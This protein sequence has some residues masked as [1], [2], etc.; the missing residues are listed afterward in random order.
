M[1]KKC[2]LAPWGLVFAFV[3]VAALAWSVA[4]EERAGVAPAAPA[5]AAGTMCVHVGTY[6]GSESR[7]IYLLELD[8]SS[9]RWVSG[10][11]LA[12]PSENPSFLALHPSGRFLYA[13]NRG[14]DSIAV[15][16]IDGVALG[17][18]PV[19]H[20]PAGGRAPRHFAIDPSGRWLIAANQDSNSLVVFRLDSATGLP[21]A[22]GSSVSVS[23]PVCVLFAPPI[24]KLLEAPAPWLPTNRA[25]PYPRRSFCPRW[26]APDCSF[27]GT[28]CNPAR[29]LGPALISGQWDS[30]WI[31]WMGPLAG[32]FAA[33][34]VFCR[35][36][37]RIE[38]AKLYR[39]DSA[40]DRLARRAGRGVVAMIVMVLCTASR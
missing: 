26:R 25:S 27:S 13:S 7:G 32:T 10:P 21:V 5:G 9:G 15:F 3:F 8:P 14:D 20:V 11:V 16:A 4:G 12:A 6:T 29:T 37:R 18:T 35:L 23:K 22:V 19:G 17:L 40:H 1:P 34:L 38:V 33:S 2:C 39:F 31:Y 30:W 36:A 28:S 24:P